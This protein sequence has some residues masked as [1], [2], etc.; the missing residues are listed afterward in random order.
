LLIY[1]ADYVWRSILTPHYVVANGV[2]EVTTVIAS[3]LAH[4]HLRSPIVRLSADPADPAQTTLELSNGE[5][6]RGFAHIIFA[7]QA[8]NAARI[9]RAG[10]DRDA[11]WADA[12][13]LERALQHLEVFR[14]VKNIVVNHSDESLLPPAEEDRR[15]LNLVTWST[16]SSLEKPAALDIDG[17]QVSRGFTMANHIVSPCAHGGRTVLQTTNPTVPIDPSTI[18]SVAQMERAVLTVQS[19]AARAAFITRED[20]LGPAQGIR[21]MVGGAR[22]WFC[23]SYAGNGIPLLEGCVVSART[24]VEKGIF[25]AE[26]VRV[27]AEPW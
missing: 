3:S 15:E 24:V 22:I 12:R 14:Y 18:M 21:A 9:L 27:R 26:G 4:I 19:K 6:H 20:E 25:A 11:G 7:T 10:P 17:L 2:R 8:N 1:I 16:P 13:Q 23:G 5:V